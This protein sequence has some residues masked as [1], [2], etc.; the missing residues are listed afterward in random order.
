MYKI[1]SFLETPNKTTFT[2]IIVHC[3]KINTLDIMVDLKDI[4]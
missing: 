4:S 2:T 1:F 3:I